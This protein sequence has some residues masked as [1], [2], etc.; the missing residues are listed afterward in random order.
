V[1]RCRGEHGVG[2]CGRGTGVV[3]ACVRA[4]TMCD[5]YTAVYTV[6]GDPAILQIG[7]EISSAEKKSQ[8]P[9]PKCK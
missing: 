6:E 5:P 7:Q 3:K 2:N 4:C 8:V 1:K 9:Q